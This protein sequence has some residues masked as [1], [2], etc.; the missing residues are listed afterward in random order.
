MLNLVVRE[1]ARRV[2]VKN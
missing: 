2:K 1:T